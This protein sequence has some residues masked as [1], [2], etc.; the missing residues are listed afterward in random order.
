MCKRHQHMYQYNNSLNSELYPSYLSYKFRPLFRIPLNSKVFLLFLQA[1]RK[2]KHHSSSFLISQLA[3]FFL[4][5]T[6]ILSASSSPVP[7]PPAGKTSFPM[8]IA[9]ETSQKKSAGLLSYGWDCLSSAKTRVIKVAKNAKKQGQDDPRK[10]IHSLKVGL[11]LSLVSL[12]YYF[13][14]LY[15]SFGVSGMWAVLTVVVVFEFTVGKLAIYIKAL[16]IIVANSIIQ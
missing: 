4:L 6:S 12:F 1:P 5:A 11:A 3:S 7:V 16:C 9:A 15:D 8:E 2:E 10:I 13:R 14:P